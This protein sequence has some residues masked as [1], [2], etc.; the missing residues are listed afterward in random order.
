MNGTRRRAPIHQLLPKIDVASPLHRTIGI[1]AANFRLLSQLSGTTSGSDTRGQHAVSS[2][3]ALRSGLCFFWG[4]ATR[5]WDGAFHDFG[6]RRSRCRRLQACANAPFDVECNLKISL[7]S[8][9]STC[10]ENVGIN[11]QLKFSSSR[12]T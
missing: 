9:F 10:D 12:K 3:A 6:L 11:E 7:E 2:R 5:T 1:A 8:T 4:R